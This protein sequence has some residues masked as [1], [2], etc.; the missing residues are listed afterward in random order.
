LNLPIG[1]EEKARDRLHSPRVRIINL[2][3]HGVEAGYIVMCDMI[4]MRPILNL[5]MPLGEGT[6]SA[7]VTHMVEAAAK[8]L[9]ECKTFAEAGVTDP[10]H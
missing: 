7:L 1:P 3:H 10:W 2:S 6:G 8:I 4:G 9:G 5:N